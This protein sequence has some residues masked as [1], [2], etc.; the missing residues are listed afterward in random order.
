MTQLM[1]LPASF[2]P[3][4]GSGRRCVLLAVNFRMTF[5]PSQLKAAGRPQALSVGHCRFVLETPARAIGPGCR[6]GNPDRAVRI[7]IGKLLD[8]PYFFLAAPGAA[9]FLRCAPYLERACLRSPT[10]WQSST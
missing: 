5:G 6:R 3:N 2:E 9:A 8:L 10:P 4:R 1:N 7:R